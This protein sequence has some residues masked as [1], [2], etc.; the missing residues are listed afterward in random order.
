MLK[1]KIVGNWPHFVAILLIFTLSGIYF[2]LQFQG[3]KLRQMDWENYL[4]MSKEVDDY[5]QHSNKET[6]WTNSMFSGMPAYQINMQTPFYVDVVNSIRRG[7]NQIIE[8]PWGYLVVGM[9]GFYLLLY[10]LGVNS[11]LALI[12]ALAFG[13]SSINILFLA[14]GHNS[15]VIA[16]ALIPPLI[17]ALFYAFRKNYLIGALLVAITTNLHVSANHL[18]M[19]YYVLFMIAA[20]GVTEIIYFAKT[21]GFAP[22]LKKSII[23]LFAAIVG[24]LPISSTLLSTYEYSKATTRGKSELTIDETGKPKERNS[25]AALGK[26]YIKEYSMGVGETWSIVVPNIKGG[27]ASYIS[28]HPE[29]MSEVNPQMREMVGS[30]S[31]Y[32]GEQRFSGGAFYF[33]AA[34]FLLFIL[35]IIFL[36]DRMKWGLLAVSLLSIALSWKY[37]AVLDWFIDNFPGFNKFR[38]TKM[39]LILPQLAFPL[40]AILFVNQLI[41]EKINQKKLIIASSAVI[42]I[43]VL[44]YLTPETFFEFSSQEETRFMEEQMQNYQGNSSVQA[45]LVAFDE[46]LTQVRVKIMQKDLGRT[47]LISVVAFLILLFFNSGKF[48][49]GWLYAVLGL[50]I[51]ADLWMVD[52]RYLNNEKVRG[53]YVNWVSDYEYFNPIRS[54]EADIQILNQEMNSNPALKSSLLTKLDQFKNTDGFGANEFNIEREKLVFRELNLATNYRVFTL[55]NPFANSQPSYFH[56]SIGGYHGAKMKKYQ[57]L[58]DFH[59]WEEYS[60]LVNVEKNGANPQ[61]FNAVLMQEGNVLNMLNTKY[62]IYNQG[63]NIMLN[64]YRYGNAWFV[65]QVSL[66]SSADDEIMALKSVNQTLAFARDTYLE[67]AKVP[68]GRDTMATISLIRYL[69]NELEYAVKSKSGQFAVFSEIYYADGWKA[70]IGDKEIPIIPVNYILRGAKLP[71][72]DYTLRFV[73]EPTIVQK[74]RLMGSIGSLLILL[75][76][77][78]IVYWKLNKKKN[79]TI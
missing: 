66:V 40:I 43:F 55:S 32:W 53:Q 52:K 25:Q 50:L 45:Q 5:Y 75:F 51:L 23:I 33:G 8:R 31:T 12:G 57:E 16:I 64:P 7:F 62:L 18:Q 73:F 30:R 21:E 29:L 37:G 54:T 46:A 48:K 63:K 19:T 44:F 79:E 24:V 13:F 60:Y 56:K 61:Q 34:I 42:G 49:S 14:G 27:T 4:G 68:S 59:L 72:G 2:N 11:W 67:E 35:G 26:D 39:M 17:G 77:G 6:F 9:I 20:I 22:V 69:P 78:A 1:D 76:A 15:K 58:I 38:D 36:K 41:K 47:I 71:E 28:N 10:W 74:G 65:D 3:F 70:F